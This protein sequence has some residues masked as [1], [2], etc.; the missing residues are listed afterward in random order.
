M[1]SVIFG[2]PGS[3]KG[4]QAAA[5]CER[6]KLAHVSTGDMLREAVRNQ[7]ELGMRAK[8]LME[9]GKLVPDELVG[10]IVRDKVAQL[11]ASGKGILF[12]G[13]PR[14]VDQ[15]RYLDTILAGLNLAVDIVAVL[16]VPAE[17]LVKRICGRR[18]CTK[19][20]C[21]GSFNIHFMP[22]RKEGVCDLCG[23]PLMQRK[24]DN[25]ETL[26]ER[27]DV[28]DKQTLPILDYYGKKELLIR[29]DASVSVDDVRSSLLA[30]I[31]NKT[32]N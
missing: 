14:N 17:N 25:E 23:S 24:D 26:R 22:S 13:Y 30:G 11:Q 15:A 7:T 18:L 20:G 9:E 4:T 5:L 16:E 32:G 10:G 28:Y 31:A 29:V 6:F 21:P 27:L 12:D 8:A 1:I 2:P 19:A 3:G